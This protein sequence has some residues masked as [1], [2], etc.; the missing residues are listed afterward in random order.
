MCIRDRINA[1]LLLDAGYPVTVFEAFHELGGVLRYGIPEFRLPNRLI[2]H[3]VERIREQGG[4][5]VKNFIA[6]KTATLDQL[7]EAGF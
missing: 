2:D 5:F 7:K 4:R 6:S 3:V 1:F